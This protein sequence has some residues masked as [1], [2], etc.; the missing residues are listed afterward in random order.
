MNFHQ[1][2]NIQNACTPRAKSRDRWYLGVLLAQS[3]SDWNIHFMNHYK[4]QGGGTQVLPKMYGDF[5]LLFRQLTKQELSALMG[6]SNKVALGRA[7]SKEDTEGQGG[8][9]LVLHFSQ[10][11]QSRD[12][13]VARGEMGF[14]PRAFP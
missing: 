2:V 7:A 11:L 6:P 10:L 1:E 14:V 13:N 12:P 8:P 5:W 4:N 3:L 9:V